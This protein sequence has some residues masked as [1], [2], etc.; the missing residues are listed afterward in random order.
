MLRAAILNL[1]HLAS[2]QRDARVGCADHV[3]RKQIARKNEKDTCIALQVLESLFLE[4]SSVQ[5]SPHVFYTSPLLAYLR[6]G[7]SSLRRHW[8]HLR[9]TC[10]CTQVVCRK[11]SFCKATRTSNIE[12]GVQDIFNAIFAM[13]DAHVFLNNLDSTAKAAVVP[14]ISTLRP[15]PCVDAI[16][17]KF[18]PSCTL[19]LA[20]TDHNLGTLPFCCASNLEHHILY[21]CQKEGDRVELS[22]L[23][24]T[25]HALV[26]RGDPGR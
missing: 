14:Y 2:T 12:R 8:K 23:S 20:L 24:R 17:V 5:H 10:T 3:G 7:S 21:K 6:I 25:T 4:V 9:S 19:R 1:A 26:G 16:D 18:L 22:A 11:S 13:S 15:T